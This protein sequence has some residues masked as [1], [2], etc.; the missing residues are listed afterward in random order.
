[1]D[2]QLDALLT[3][4]GVLG[5]I[6]VDRRGQVLAHSALTR[7]DA[8]LVSTVASTIFV[9]LAH[10]GGFG[11][12]AGPEGATPR[13]YATFELRQGQ[14]HLSA[15]RELAL[16]LLTEPGLDQAPVRDLLAGLVADLE[17]SLSAGPG[18]RPD[19]PRAG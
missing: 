3:I 15:G 14:I 2:V 13:S 10:S 6:A 7:A 19:P 9:D 12:L 5:A 1:V 18:P 16:I 4:K 8:E 11:S 17:R